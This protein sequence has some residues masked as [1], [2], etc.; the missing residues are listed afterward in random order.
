MELRLSIMAMRMPKLFRT[1]IHLKK[2]MNKL[3]D[4]TFPALVALFL[5]GGI[6]F[7]WQSP[8]TEVAMAL[9]ADSQT[10]AVSESSINLEEVEALPTA[11][12]QELFAT[13][14]ATTTQTATSTQ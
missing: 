13:S 7:F 11:T 12:L 1:N 3:I 6:Y 8:V 4:Y 10:A 9:P 2:C 5:M 14:S